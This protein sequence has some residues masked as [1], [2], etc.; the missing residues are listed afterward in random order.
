MLSDIGAVIE[1]QG[2]PR[3]SKGRVLSIKCLYTASV[4]SKSS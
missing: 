2:L 3:G 4:A 1:W